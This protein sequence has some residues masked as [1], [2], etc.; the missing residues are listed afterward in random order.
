MIRG[1]RL[2]RRWLQRVHPVVA[3]GLLAAAVLGLDLA[4][5]AEVI[6]HDPAASPGS[7]ALGYVLV[8]L[9]TVPLVFRRRF[10]RAVLATI[11]AGMTVYFVLGYTLTGTGESLLIAAY[12]AASRGD[13]RS[14]L[15]A[16]AG[17]VAMIAVGVATARVDVAPIEVVAVMALYT[18][19]CWLGANSRT[20]RR[21]AAELELRA[22]Q[23]ERA[24][25]EL[26]YRAVADERLRIARE[27]HDVVAHSMSVIAVQ[28]GAGEHVSDR[29]PEV[30]RQALTDIK[31]TSRAALAEMRRLLGVLRQQDQP[32]ADLAPLAGLADVQALARSVGQAGIRVSVHTV[33]ERGQVPAAV[34]LSAYRI[35]Q[36]ALT[37]V[38]KH[39]PAATAT[40]TIRYGRDD[41]TVDI[42]D[43]GADRLAPGR[44][45]PAYDGGNGIVGMRERVALFAGELETGPLAGGGFR[46]R[47]R[48][49]YAEPVG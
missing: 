3:D 29:R 13:L 14:T 39:A 44:T 26:A 16:H 18:A 35:V 28:S 23:L 48:L 46:V 33:G 12:T 25:Q 38:L 21:Y 20:R 9:F 17:F 8:A 2:V 36:E 4:Q 45:P 10:P 32:T 49:P 31:V 41:V 43:D 11:L 37:N 40:V 22:A 47:A 19:A 30:A 24:R 6:R 42:R 1:V 5:R 15:P 27:L 7:D 34:D